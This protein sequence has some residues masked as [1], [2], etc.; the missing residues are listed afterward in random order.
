MLHGNWTGKAEV[1]A[2]KPWEALTLGAGGSRWGLDLKEAM[3]MER[4]MGSLSCNSRMCW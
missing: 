1:E 3:E 4:S 2:R